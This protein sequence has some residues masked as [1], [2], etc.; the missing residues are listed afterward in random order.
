MSVETEVPQTEAVSVQ[1][2][3]EVPVDVPEVSVN[4]PEV[5]IDV[6]ETTVVQTAVEPVKKKRK[7]TEAQVNALANA[8]KNKAAKH[9]ILKK[10]VKIERGKDQ[11]SEDSSFSWPKEVAKVSCLAA[12]GLASVFVQQRFAQN[13]IR[14]VANVIEVKPVLKDEEKPSLKR[15]NISSGD[16]F[17]SYR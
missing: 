6:Q 11:T 7:R 10:G 16:P 5:S 13:Q 12:L 2:A 14:S 3:L 4:T 1:N 17:G 9:K 8:R 15:P